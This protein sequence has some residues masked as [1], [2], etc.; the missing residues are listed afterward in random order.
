MPTTSP[1][2][3]LSPELNILSEQDST[4][5]QKTNITSEMPFKISDLK[6]RNS[7]PPPNQRDI[8]R[9][10]TQGSIQGSVRVDSPLGSRTLGEMR[11]QSPNLG[12][13]KKINTTGLPPPPPQLSGLP[14]NVAR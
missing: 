2:Q 5:K 1:T 4:V 3:R 10:T 7:I 9:K 11:S 6:P 13:L 8:V 12:S 14:R